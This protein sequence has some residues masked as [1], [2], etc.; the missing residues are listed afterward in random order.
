MGL[1]LFNISAHSSTSSIM[2]CAL[3]IKNCALK[4]C[5]LALFCTLLAL[6]TFAQNTIGGQAKLVAEAEVDRQRDFV[7]AET[8]RMLGKY[9]KAIELY[10]K[11]IYD[12]EQNDAA[13]YGLGRSEMAKENLPAALDA[14]RKAT[15][16]APTNIWYQIFLSELYEKAGRY[17]DAVAIAEKLTKEAPQHIPYF[18]RLAYLQIL[19]GTP[20]DALKTLDRLERITGLTETLAERR[21]LI[22]VAMRDQ[23]RAAEALAQ[24]ADAQPYVVEY[25]RRLAHYY[26]EIG[27]KEA[28][29]KAYAQ[30][31]TIQP[32]DPEAKLAL[33]S[34]N[35]AAKTSGSGDVAQLTALQP[36]F[37]DPRAPLEAKFKQITPYLSKLKNNTDPAFTQ[38]MLEL[39]RIV[40]AAHP[41]DATAWSL[42]GMLFY[43]ANQPD[44]ALERYQ[45]CIRLNPKAFSVWDNTLDI[46][47]QQQQY[48]AMLRTAEQAIDAFP[49]QAKAYWYYAVAAN[50]TGQPADARSNAEQALLMTNDAAIQLDLAD[51]MGL[52]MLL[53]KD[54]GAATTHY[55]AW[56]NK[57][58]DRHA[59]ILEHYGD[60][61]FQKGDT[62]KAQAQWQK[63]LGIQRTPALER[64]AA[65]GKL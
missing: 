9:D 51:Q 58:G 29:R 8:A 49:N 24:L 6:S 20:N 19:N 55:E 16:L 4:T 53:Q 31:A 42:S 60:A 27:N 56:L 30:I 17:A 54:F 46:L 52:S 14:A 26:E 40:E 32:N 45:R 39:G 15:T 36:L 38:A 13:W 57:G 61:L 48:A 44:A 34:A 23:K 21:H 22:Y 64:K 50:A 10:K 25:R 35:N 2:H 43:Q 11:F 5:S 33:M 62:A 65:D 63:A 1:I 3:R 12:N 28:A 18:E 47:R 7:D 59:G 41:D 37:K